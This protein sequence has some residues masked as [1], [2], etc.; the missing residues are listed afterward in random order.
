M[1]RVFM[2]FDLDKSGYLEQNELVD[3]T[4]AVLVCASL[5]H[6]IREYEEWHL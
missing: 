3:L 4:E 2:T 1:Y 5:K 6:H